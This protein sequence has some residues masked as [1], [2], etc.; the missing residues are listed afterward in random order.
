MYGLPTVVLPSDTV[1]VDSQP[2][3]PAERI[4]LVH[5]FITSSKPDGGLGIIPG[6][7]GWDLIES[8][9][10]LHDRE[11]NDTW[12]RSWTLRQIASVQLSKIREQVSPR[13]T[14]PP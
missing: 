7:S 14:P 2:L 8:I 12:N 4:R 1:K 11:F 9:M 13:R 10:A 3:S 5:G 6:S